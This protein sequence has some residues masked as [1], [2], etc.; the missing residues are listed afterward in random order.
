MVSLNGLIGVAVDVTESKKSEQALLKSEERLRLS[1]KAAKQGL[2]DL[3]IQT[4]EAIVSDEYAL[5][6]GY[7]PKTI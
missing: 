2:Y 6:L 3:N 5:M 4:G 1:L 7:D